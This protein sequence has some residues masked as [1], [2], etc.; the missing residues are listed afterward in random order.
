[1]ERY[2]SERSS[3]LLSIGLGVGIAVFGLTSEARAQVIRQGP[4]GRESTVE[5]Q[6]ED[7][8]II[9]TTTGPNGEVRESTVIRGEDGGVIRT[10]PNGNAATT[11]RQVEDGTLIRTTTG[12][13]GEVR[14]TT[15]VRT[16]DGTVVNTGPNGNTTTSDRTVEDGQVTR[17][18][19]GPGG[20]VWSRIRD[21]TRE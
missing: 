10:G 2:G 14:E 16:E 9:R 15:T 8:A 11:E 12:P 20:R 7:G 17:E 21:Q 4:N 18:T 1:M 3:V 5:R 6:V 13:N 19:T